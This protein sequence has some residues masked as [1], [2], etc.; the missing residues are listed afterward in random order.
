MQGEKIYEGGLKD[1][2]QEGKGTTEYH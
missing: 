1:G 2:K